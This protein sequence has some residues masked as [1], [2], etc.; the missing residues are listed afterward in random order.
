MQA[1]MLR[2]RLMKPGNAVDSFFSAAFTHNHSICMCRCLIPYVIFSFFIN[3][4]PH[5]T[6]AQATTLRQHLIGQSD[7]V[8]SVATA[9][10]RARCGL[11]DPNR[12]VASLL[13]VGPTGEDRCRQ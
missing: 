10:Q 3:K 4:P 2:Q 9:L 8:D 12:P 5:T 6:C 1:R 7:A 11:K 13:F